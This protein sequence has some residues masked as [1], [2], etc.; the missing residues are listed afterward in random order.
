MYKAILIPI[1]GSVNAE[2]AAGHGLE[3]ARLTNAKVVILYVIDNRLFQGLS[4]SEIVPYLKNLS[5]KAQ[6]YIKKVSGMVPGLSYEEIIVQGFPAEEIIKIAEDERIDLIV[7]GTR[8]I[9]GPKRLLLGS[10]AEEA[11]KFA[12]CAVLVVK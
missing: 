10:T 2:K 4:K 9:T 12:Q 8:G 1:D 11:I 7:M 6:E 5:A 3:I